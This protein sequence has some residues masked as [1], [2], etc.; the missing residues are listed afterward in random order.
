MTILTC[1][2]VIAVMK[3][4]KEIT[5]LPVDREALVMLGREVA[6]GLYLFKAKLETKDM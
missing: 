1:L 6:L 5:Y 4:A 2:M 3:M